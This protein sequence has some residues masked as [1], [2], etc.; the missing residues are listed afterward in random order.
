[1]YVSREEERSIPIKPD[2]ELEF[3]NTLTRQA[4]RA[5]GMYDL[6][7]RIKKANPE[8][9]R[10]TVR[11]LARLLHKNSW[12]A[13]DCDMIRKSKARLPYIR[14]KGSNTLAKECGIF[15]IERP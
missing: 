4:L 3:I 9:D 7:Q 5:T 6:R 10:H 2:D 12:D 13:R 15:G 11:D 1:M 14:K 8:L